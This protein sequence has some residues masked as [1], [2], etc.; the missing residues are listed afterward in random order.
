MKTDREKL[1]ELI[2]DIQLFGRMEKH[3]ECSITFWSPKNEDLAD[4]LL[5]NGVTLAKDMDVP[6]KVETN[7]FDQE[8][9]HHNCTVQILTNSVT[10][11]RSIGWWPEN[12]P[13]E[14]G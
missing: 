6:S 12:E 8:E 3:E 13:P 7:I 9:I 2:R 14:E 4:H 1:I 5:A 10:G 11:E